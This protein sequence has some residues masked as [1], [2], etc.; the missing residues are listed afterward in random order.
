MSLGSSAGLMVTASLAIPSVQ[1]SFGKNIS[2]KPG[3][4]FNPID[5]AIGMDFLSSF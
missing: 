5:F 1:I 4:Q 2:H 3:D